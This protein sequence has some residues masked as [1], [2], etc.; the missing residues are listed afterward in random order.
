MTIGGI[1]FGALGPIM[2]LI[3][4][5]LGNGKSIWIA[6]CSQTALSIPL[7]LWGAP[8]CA[9]LVEA[10]E[11]GAR[12]T[13]VSIGYNVAQAIAGGISPFVATL[14]VDK[15]GTGAPGLLLLALAV[16]SLTGLLYVAPNQP[17]E[18][19]HRSLE[20]AELSLELKEMT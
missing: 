19:A 5:H 17:I 12:L 20:E 4:G 2:I 15:V 3:I 9:W 11:P 16:F 7:A 14:L 10:F 18:Q 6:F 8:M 1:V 13:S